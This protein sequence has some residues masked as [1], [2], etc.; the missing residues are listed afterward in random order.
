MVHTHVKQCNMYT[1]QCP[2]ISQFGF[3]FALAQWC[4]IIIVLID[5]SI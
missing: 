4:D 1:K 2:V 3:Y 5:Y